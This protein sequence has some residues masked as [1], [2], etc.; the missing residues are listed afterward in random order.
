MAANFSES[1]IKRDQERDTRC[2]SVFLLF[3]L[4]RTS[5][6]FCHILLIASESVR[7]THSQEAGIQ[8]RT[9]TRGRIIDGISDA[10]YH[11]MPKSSWADRKSGH[12]ELYSFLERI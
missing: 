2:K 3:N 1:S 11:N 12:A 9:N 10:A 6:Y 7:P 5:H 8:E 4:G